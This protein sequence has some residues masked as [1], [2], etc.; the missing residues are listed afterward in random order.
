M[1]PMNNSIDKKLLKLILN[2]NHNLVVELSK[3][4]D[5][6]DYISDNVDRDL[7][8][9]IKALFLECVGEDEED[10]YLIKG[11]QKPFVKKHSQRAA[12]RNNLRQEIRDK[13]NKS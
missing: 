6:P 13:I 4:D 3:M 5:D 1:E 11:V 10:Y 2:H 8:D 7:I 12:F 9:Q